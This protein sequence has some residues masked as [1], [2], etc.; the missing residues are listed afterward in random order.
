MRVGIGYDVH[1]LVKN[2]DLILGGIKFE[3]EWGLLGHSDADVL[4]HAIMDAIL[5]ALALPD[6]GNLFPDTDPAY[7]DIYSIDLLDKVVEK[8][9]EK[10]YKI[11]NIDSV[12]ICEL[13]KIAPKREEITKL[14]ANHL[15]TD[16]TKVSV[17]ASTSEKL[18]FTGQGEGIEA[19]AIVYLEEINA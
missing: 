19:R 11:G 12:I 8:M 9:Y 5:G 4:T 6:I 18:G 14:L 7:K 10:G 17:K 1:K 15:K 13:P 16:I 3:S 2:R